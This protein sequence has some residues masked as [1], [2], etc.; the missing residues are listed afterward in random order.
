MD[1]H[2]IRLGFGCMRFPQDKEGKIDRAELRQMIDA[3]LAGQITYFDT[4]YVYYDG[5]S[6]A[7]LRELLVKRHARQRFRLA[8][9]LA[10]W[11]L[12]EGAGPREMMAMVDEQL[13]RLGVEHIDFYLVHSL[14][15][16]TWRSLLDKGVL[17]F[18][19][20]LRKSGKVG[21][22][23]FSFHDAPAQLPA[24]RDAFAWD[25][26][27]LQINYFDWH[28]V[29]D[30]AAQYRMAEEKDLPIVIMEPVRGGTLAR[31]P[32][33]AGAVLRG[34]GYDKSPASLALRWA[35]SLP[36]AR[37][38]LSG[39]SSLRQME[40]NIAALGTDFQPLDAQE[41][42]LAD[43]VAQVLHDTDLVPCTGCAYCKP[44]CPQN[45]DIPLLLEKLNDYRQFH[46]IALLQNFLFPSAY[47]PRSTDCLHCG[48]CTAVCPQSL[49]IPA[50]IEEFRAAVR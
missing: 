14:S 4:A 32:E 49:D 7:L 39:M 44:E 33:K 23:G 31:L 40:E 19:A 38:V 13:V 24:I 5:E 1:Y 36:Q 25:F 20:S 8:D 46:D 17:D 42:A 34:A 37:V 3:A 27:Q 28:G 41:L 26:V 16:K 43:A 21:D 9:K 29:Q 22:I 10:G 15:G 47:P 18:L 45:I 48:K 6:E 30:A 50:Y 35:A 2:G 12:P 11:R